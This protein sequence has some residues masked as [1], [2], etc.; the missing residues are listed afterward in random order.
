MRNSVISIKSGRRFG[1]DGTSIPLRFA[2]SSAYR[3]AAE[4]NPTS[5]SIGGCKRQD[6]VRVSTILCSTDSS[7]ADNASAL[8]DVS[9][10]PS[11][12]KFILTLAK[13]CPRLS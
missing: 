7:A 3:R 9:E 1:E 8:F 5:S 12:S 2:N 4:A 13:Y 10:L 11:E 6:K